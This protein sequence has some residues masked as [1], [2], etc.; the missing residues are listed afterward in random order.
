MDT[1]T[2]EGV[3][4][5]FAGSMCFCIILMTITIYMMGVLKIHWVPESIG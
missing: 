3:D 4:A 5:V 1:F 2:F